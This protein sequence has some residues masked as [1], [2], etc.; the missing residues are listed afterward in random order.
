MRRDARREG[1]GQ[2]SG[3]GIASTPWQI[4]SS[5]GSLGRTVSLRHARSTPVRLPTRGQG[6]RPAHLSSFDVP[7]GRRGQ[8][9]RRLGV[10]P[11]GQPDPRGARA[12]PGRAR[13]RRA[14][15]R[16]RQW[17][18]GR[19]LHLAHAVCA[20]RPRRD[21]GRCVRR[22]VPV[23]RQGV[24]PLGGCARVGRPVGP[25]R[26]RPCDDPENLGGVVR[27]PEQSA[28]RYR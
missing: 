19:G 4:I 20:L 10:Q 6:P 24:R 26:T 28:A 13:G 25:R 3:C 23:G 2:L 9:A 12:V 5:T 16:L 1:H 15:A 17:S 8:S 11:V 21:T 22:H 14:W 7:T 18:R 27:D